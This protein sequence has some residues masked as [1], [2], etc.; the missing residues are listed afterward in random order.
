MFLHEGSLFTGCSDSSP[1]AGD[2][3]RVINTSATSCPNWVSRDDTKFGYDSESV[4]L[5]H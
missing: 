5:L 3:G 2:Q 4:A 1:N